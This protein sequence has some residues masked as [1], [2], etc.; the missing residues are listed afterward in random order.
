MIR[1]ILIII[2]FF[3]TL[4]FVYGQDIKGG[5]IRSYRNGIDSSDNTFTFNVYLY[6]QSSMGINHSTIYVYMGDGGQPIPVSGT[7][8]YLYNDISEWH[9]AFNHTYLGNGFYNLHISDSFRIVGIQN[10]TNSSLE[11][12]YLQSPIIINPF[13][14]W[15]SSPQ[16]Q[17]RQTA[18]FNNS[19]YFVHNASA[20]DPEGDSLSYS[21]VPATSTS[22][23]FPTGATINPIT[24]DFQMPFASGIYAINIRIDEWR[25]GVI[26]GTT[27]REMVLDSNTI[28][29]VNNINSENPIF[30]ILPNP[31]HDV[32]HL[33]FREN[34]S[35]ASTSIFNLEG[36]EVL[37]MSKISTNNQIDISS[38][39]NGIYFLEINDGS[40][41]LY[42]KFIKE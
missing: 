10:I 19:G 28:I 24:G 15:N 8:M 2:T 40:K 27:Y 16:F 23:S 39:A 5:E 30:T 9:Y 25:S 18:V 1:L 20:F 22:Y 11:S 33:I 41:N 3:I 13:L 21:L 12:I 26:V 37:R 42:R 4:S 36:Q 29:G 14:G 35:V 38:F 31:V 34:V 7:S 32:L 6:T 17:D